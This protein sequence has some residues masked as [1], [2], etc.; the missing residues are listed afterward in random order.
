MSC[1]FL[2][3]RKQLWI[4]IDENKQQYYKQYQISIKKSAYNSNRMRTSDLINQQKSEI[5]KT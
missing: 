1:E 5:M 2:T 4:N 3:D